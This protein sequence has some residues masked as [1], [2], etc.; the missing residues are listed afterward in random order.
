[1]MKSSFPRYRRLAHPLK[2][3]HNQSPG[4]EFK[5]LKTISHEKYSQIVLKLKT[6]IRDVRGRVLNTNVNTNVK[7]VKYVIRNVVRNVIYVINI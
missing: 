2:L 5:S 3:R 6:N 7:Y 1:M 4:Q